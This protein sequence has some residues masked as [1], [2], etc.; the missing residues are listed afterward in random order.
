MNKKVYT[1]EVLGGYGILAST[2]E[3]NQSSVYVNGEYVDFT[4]QQT[5]LMIDTS[6]MQ[7]QI[8]TH[9]SGIGRS[10]IHAEILSFLSTDS[11][12]SI[13][14]NELSKILKKKVRFGIVTWPNEDGTPVFTC[15]IYF[16]DKLIAEQ[17][18]EKDDE[19]INI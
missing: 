7:N 9:F 2:S 4:K 18:V 15:Q 5:L 17:T 6:V 3:Q 8:Q 14:Q 10:Q 16:N 1:T 11:A 13:L 19:K 12:E